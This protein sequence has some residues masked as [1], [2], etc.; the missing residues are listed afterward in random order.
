M[1][2]LTFRRVGRW[3][4]LAAAALIG[5]SIYGPFPALDLVVAWAIFPALTLSGLAMWFAPA[6]LRRLRGA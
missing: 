2:P 3:L 1:T 4:H 5:T 6:I